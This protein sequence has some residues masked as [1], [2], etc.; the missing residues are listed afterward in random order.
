MS[1]HD[2]KPI[3]PRFWSRVEKSGG[4]WN[5]I[6]AKQAGG[7]GQLYVN[8][9]SRR[10][11]HVSWFICYGRWP[12]AGK[13]L[14]HTCDVPS[15]VNPA[16]L[17]EGTQRENQRDTY[18][19]GPWGGRKALAARVSQMKAATHCRNGHPYTDAKAYQ[20]G[21][22]AGRRRCMECYRLR[23]AR[24]GNRWDDRRADQQRR[25]RQARKSA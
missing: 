11:T 6:G 9:R 16:H 13:M 14:C 22:K 10:A 18:E 3:E 17:Y 25:Q 8:G 5:W 1:K 2:P 4:C 19:R 21:E 20:S 12:M 15:C 23:E 7:Y 24:R